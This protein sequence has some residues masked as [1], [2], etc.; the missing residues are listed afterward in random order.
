MLVS[1]T[2][3]LDCGLQ[4]ATL[5]GIQQIAIQADLIDLDLRQRL[6][7]WLLHFCSMSQCTPTKIYVFFCQK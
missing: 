1:N 3:V 6:M 5:P 7:C 4:S 2:V